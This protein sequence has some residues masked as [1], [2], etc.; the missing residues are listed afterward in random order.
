MK[1][2]TSLAILPVSLVLLLGGRTA[3]ATAPFPENFDF[4]TV[5]DTYVPDSHPLDNPGAIFGS[6]PDNGNTFRTT[7]GGSF[8]T[9]YLD[10]RNGSYGLAVSVANN[11]ETSVGLPAVPP[12]PNPLFPGGSRH[13]VVWPQYGYGPTMRPSKVDANVSGLPYTDQAQFWGGTNNLGKVANWTQHA[14][15]YQIGRASC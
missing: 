3:W 9:G 13:L 5:S 4:E 2:R 7:S 12:D 15:L 14:D 8:T 6:P 11:W 1:Q 10:G